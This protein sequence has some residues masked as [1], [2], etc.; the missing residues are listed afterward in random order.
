MIITYKQNA[1]SERLE[2]K[3]PLIVR[4]FNYHFPHHLSVTCTCVQCVCEENK[5]VFNI[6]TVQGTYTRSTVLL[7]LIANILFEIKSLDQEEI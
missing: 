2:I 3:A 1:I 6:T 5:M 7:E 4:F